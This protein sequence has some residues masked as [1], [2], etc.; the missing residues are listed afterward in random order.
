MCEVLLV[1]I[2][3]TEEL[4][5]IIHQLWGTFAVIALVLY[6]RPAI[7]IVGAIISKSGCHR[8]TDICYCR[9][10]TVCTQANLTKT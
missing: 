7:K 5:S 4:E 6:H 8:H 10:S 3:T 2:L 9:S 1:S